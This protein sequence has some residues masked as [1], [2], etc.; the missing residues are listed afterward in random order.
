MFGM[1]TCPLATWLCR[2]PHDA[3]DNETVGGMN[4]A[5]RCPLA[6]SELD[7]AVSWEAL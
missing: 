4:H 7:G 3:G 5:F 1:D 6:V 2:I